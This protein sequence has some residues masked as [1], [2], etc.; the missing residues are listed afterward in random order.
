MIEKR[1]LIG[2]LLFIG[3]GIASPVSGQVTSAQIDSVLSNTV[4]E[5]MRDIRPKSYVAPRIDLPMQIDGIL[6]DSAWGRAKWSSD[7]V[8]IE[9]AMKPPPILRTR[10]KM[11][12]DEEYLYIG[13]QL[14]E[15]QLWATL[16]EKNSVI[17]HDDDFEIFIDPNG[18][19]HNY[20]EF[21]VNALNTIWELRLL[22]PYRD[23]GP[24]ISGENIDGLRSAVALDGTVN[25]P[26]D[27][28]TGWSVEVAIPW[29]GLRS[30]QA[31]RLPPEPGDSW[32]I[33]FSRVDHAVDVVNGLYVKRDGSASNN[34]VWC[35]QGVV[36]MHM[37]ERWGFVQF[38][39]N[40]GESL[41]PIP[42]QTMNYRDILMEIYYRQK[43]LWSLTNAF[44]ADLQRLFH[45][46]VRPT[47]GISMASTDTTFDAT[48]YL[49][50]IGSNPIELRINES[51]R[52]MR[53]FR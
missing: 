24:A 35:Q 51:G 44:T 37:P 5:R 46:S 15:P 34:W 49:D 32:R 36:D 48:I 30:M 9:G 6:D 20:Y 1:R 4:W 27:V 33:N 29:Y 43:A 26:R 25:D 22:R 16:T 28:D 21:E 12:W 8:D 31:K 3:A 53:S 2:I 10:M 23:G 38:S 17:F 47:N 11:V 13:A 41:T 45:D 40:G 14:E 50:F 39:N 18:D 42:D 52:L 19:N 7:F